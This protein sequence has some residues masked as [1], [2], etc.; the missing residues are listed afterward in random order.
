MNG[1]KIG[2]KYWQYTALRGKKGDRGSE[3][4]KDRDIN[5]FHITVTKY[6]SSARFTWFLLKFH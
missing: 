1:A 5:V 3:L 6:I 4:P 2:L